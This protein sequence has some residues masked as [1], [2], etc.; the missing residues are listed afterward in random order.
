M[1][2]NLLI[3]TLWLFLPWFGHAQGWRPGEMEVRVRITSPSDLNRLQ[4]I[5][6]NIELAEADG[7]IFRA[8]VT[9]EEYNLMKEDGL[10]AFVVI[11]NLNNHYRNFWDNPLVPPGYY[12]YEQ[13]ISIAD[14]LAANYP[15]ICKKEIW[16]NSVA[17]RQLAVLKIS[18]NAAINEDEPEIMFDGGIHGDEVGGSQNV[19]M[20]A[21]EL[22]KSYGS[23]VTITELVDTREIFL[24]LMVNPDGRVSMSRYNQNGVD[25]NRD[26]GYMWDGEGYSP[27]A[28]SQPETR[29]LRN[30]L[31][32]HNFTCYT[33]FHS[34]IEIISCPWS[35]RPQAPRDYE[36]ILMLAAAYSNASGYAGGLQFGQG[37]NIMYPINGS[38]KDFQYGSLGHA[39][40]SI[41]ISTDKQP[42]SSQIQYFYNLN[43][44]AMLEIIRQCGWGVS[45]TVTDSLTGSPVQATIWV[46]SFYPV[47]TDPAVGDY[48]KF[49]APG[50]ITVTVT[51]NGY[52]QKTLT[53]I[54]VPAQGTATADFQL[55]PDTGW[56]ASKVI[57]CRIPNNNQGDEG[58]TPGCLGK[59]DGIPYAVGKN[60]W[61]I[62]DMGDTLYNGIG[63]DFRVYQSGTTNK[64]FT[65]SGSLLVDGPFTTIGTGTGS[66][67][68]DL[69]VSLPKVKYIYL[70][71]NG[72]GSASGV[73]AGFNLDAISMLASPLK[74]AFSASDTSPCSGTGVNFT[75]MSGG[76]PVSWNWSFPGGTPSSSTAQHPTGIRYDQPGN[77]AVSLTISNGISG[78]TTTMEDF[79]VVIDAPEV[80]LGNDTLVCDYDQVT[81]EAGNPGAVY[82]W[83]TGQNTPAIT[84]DSSGTGYGTAAFWVLVTAANGCE[85]RDTIQITW[86]NCT[87]AEQRVGQP[88]TIVTPNP[89]QDQITL[90]FRGWRQGFWE[91]VNLQGT[92]VA[93]G[94]IPSDEH[95][96]ELR[97]DTYPVGI[98]LL[99]AEN[100]S[101]RIIRKI[102]ISR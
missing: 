25:C 5:T 73:G 11:P 84:V 28:V 35:Y 9:P 38:T 70:K 40:W 77:Y 93:K 16:G 91:I 14:S 46:N 61:I 20:F 1:F 68:F 12:T 52:K 17:G 83:S 81:L 60:G 76:N 37:Y 85:G 10:T 7:N 59:P 30:G 62:L 63:E 34:G 39:G 26:N 32:E 6:S 41:E 101:F 43:K 88:V 65:V 24:F 66:T 78:V 72:N 102:I 19:I 53:G 94:L 69:P 13:I 98:Y 18:D 80:F 15:S 50:T 90:F 67:S 45:G 42:P 47:F 95:S 4:E 64:S 92:T 55:A 22:C 74:A 79:I 23:D 51:A 31:L 29:A 2:K 82:L 33:N 89:A 44:P 54:V 97:C 36:H 21:R 58:Y 71:D 3:A 8:Y 49:L 48:H 99:K 56:Y 96:I 75:D 86:D 87:G 100:P 27:S 57:S